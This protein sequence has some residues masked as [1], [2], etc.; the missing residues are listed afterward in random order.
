MSIKRHVV[1]Y[2]DSA[3][4]SGNWIPLYT[5]YAG[6]DQNRTI[7]VNMNASDTVDIEGTTIEAKDATDLG[8]VAAEDITVIKSYTGNTDENDALLGSFTFVR[9]TKTGT[10]G[11]AKVQGQI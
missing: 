10:N 2:N 3:A 1:L 5:K 4:G 11:T 8:T 7:Q 9:V 6:G